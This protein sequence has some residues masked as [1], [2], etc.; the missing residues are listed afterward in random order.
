MHISGSI[1]V[2]DRNSIEQMSKNQINP[3]FEMRG[4]LSIRLLNF[5]HK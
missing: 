5:G 4:E 3:K 1:R 2:Y